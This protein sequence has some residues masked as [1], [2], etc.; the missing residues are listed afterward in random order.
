MNS[1]ADNIL[2]EANGEDIE[3]VVIGAFGYGKGWHAPDTEQVI[4]R[5]KMGVALPWAGA[6]V[7]LDYEYYTG[8]G[9]PNCHAVWAWTA[10]RV[11]FV[12]TYDG[13]TSVTSVPRNPRDGTPSMPGGG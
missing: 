4:P 3:S 2:A 1:F 8:F 7:L 11:I 13:S 9:A 5:E 6:S 12:S 10:S